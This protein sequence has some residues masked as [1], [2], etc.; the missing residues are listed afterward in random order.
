MHPI[1]EYI[2]NLLPPDKKQ[3][4]NGE[5]SFN[6]VCCYRSEKPDTKKR[7]GVKFFDDGFVYNCFNCKFSCG[8]TL[9]KFLSKKCVQ[10]L[11]DCGSTSE[12]ITTLFKMIDEYNSTIG[13]STK[14]KE[15][16]KPRIIR[17]IPPEYKSIKES[18]YK[19]EN[20]KTLK[21]VYT[22][23]S[24]RN[25]RLLSWAD[26]LWAEGRDN[27]L[28]PCYEFNKIVGYSLRSIH[29]ES[30][31]KYIHY[32]PSGY[33]FNFDNLTKDRKYQI[34]VEGQTDALAING[35]ALLSNVFTPEKLKR[36]LEYKGNSEIILVPDRDRPGLKMIQQ[37]LDENLPFS[38]SF[39]SWQKGI[40]DVEEAVKRYGRLYTIYDIIKN[41]ESDK[42]R[43]KI[44]MG[45]WIKE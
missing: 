30:E 39:P 17:D 31:H 5:I 8:F 7:G 38:V 21:R 25:E 14:N 28:I 19:G 3:K 26:L 42:N 9:G 1:L 2:Y 23:I 24:Q 37:L 33:I 29:D 41:K 6:G 10:F 18:L 15:I 32:V 35:V 36:L 34:V 20:S 40:K 44:K 13:T 16:I 43:I 12:Q 11:R 4:A 22:Y 27:F 45:G